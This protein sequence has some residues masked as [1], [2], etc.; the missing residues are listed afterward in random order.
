MNLNQNNLA[1]AGR[2]GRWTALCLALGCVWIGAWPSRA[3]GAVVSFT[4]AT[5]IPIVDGFPPNPSTSAINIPSLPGVLQSVTVTVYGLTDASTG[6]IELLLQ[7]PSGQGIDLMSVAGNGGAN[8]I[9]IT[10]ADSGSPFPNSPL[11]SGTYKPSGISYPSYSPF[12]GENTTNVL[13]GFVG[14]PSAGNWTLSEYYADFAGSDGTISGGWSLTF[15]VTSGNPIVTTLAASGITGT[16]ATLNAGVN[17]NGS[18]TFVFYQFGPTTAYGQFSSPIVLSADL[19]DPQSVP[20]NV[21]LQPGTTYHYRA[22]AQNSTGITYG[23]DLTL[24]TPATQVLL[25]ASITNRTTL[26]LNLTGKNGSN[27]VVMGTT[28]LASPI[29]WTPLVTNTLTNSTQPIYVVPATNLIEIFRVE[30]Q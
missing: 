10:F 8:N 27:Y 24:T 1:Q 16:N 18:D 21:P 14:T 11:V 12:F 30:Q 6:G 19:G 20:V 13:S 7:G 5:A 29:N 23:S 26:L 9:T 2:S 15:N 22:V 28:N 4:N 3:A 17:P 25:T